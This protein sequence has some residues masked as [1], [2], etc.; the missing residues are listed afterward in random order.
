MLI[1]KSRPARSLPSVASKIFLRLIQNRHKPDESNGFGSTNVRH[2]A[3]TP[4]SA[5]KPDPKAA[6]AA[7]PDS[8]PATKGLSLYEELFPDEAAKDKAMANKPTNY[9]KASTFLPRLPTPK[10]MEKEHRR[11]ARLSNTE[12]FPSTTATPYDVDNAALLVL[13]GASR[14]LSE[15][16]F[17]RIA[18]KG[19]HIK[20]WKNGPGYF[21]KV[22]PGRDPSTLTQLP[23]Y[24]L[25]FSKPSNAL[26]YMRHIQ[27][28]HRTSQSYTP[29]SIESPLP[30]QP[31]RGPRRSKTTRIITNPAEG[32]N[33]EQQ[34]LSSDD[35]IVG[36]E[37]VVVEEEEEDLY[38]LLR[39]YTL[40]PPS[41]RLK[42]RLIK[43]PFSWG[44]KKLVEN[45]GYSPI[46]RGGP[47]GED[48]SGRAVLFWVEGGR[49]PRMGKVERVIAADGKERDM[50]WD[51]KVD[52]LDFMDTEEGEL[53]ERE[54]KTE[55]Q[56]QQQQ[57]GRI[58]RWILSFQEEDE[59]RR[60]VRRWHQ[61][62]FPLGV[63]A[64][65][66][67]ACAELLW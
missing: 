43:A 61:R 4:G 55:Q 35:D 5:P 47:N 59:A 66:T 36:E 30:L 64:E 58:K 2:P 19:Q 42:L 49:Q 22:F 45:A 6:P 3:H 56:Q 15:D 50:P 31:G 33:P 21:H 44:T 52:E 9:D 40:C 12:N 57:R 34:R 16:D 25:I 51:C 26:T 63:G 48:L 54:W 41:Q 8:T 18:P 29:T 1:L 53:G 39:D 24:F 17:R 67:R 27:N 11:L 65:E 7:Q 62:E 37:E 13:Q 10:L 32:R 60:F 38:A 28:V 14:S 23:H 46:T 20:D